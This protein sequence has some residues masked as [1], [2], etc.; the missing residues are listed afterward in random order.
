MTQTADQ[1]LQAITALEGVADTVR[2]EAAADCIDGA[3]LEAFWR[4]W[5]DLSEWVERLWKRLDDDFGGPARPVRDPLRDETGG[6][7]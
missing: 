4:E 5:P 6:G 3:T 1:L 2:P 7:D